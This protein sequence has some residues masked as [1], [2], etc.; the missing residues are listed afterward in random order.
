MFLVLTRNSSTESIWGVPE[1]RQRGRGHGRKADNEIIRLG[2][3]SVVDRVFVGSKG[4][5]TRERV[6]MGSDAGSIARYCRYRVLVV[7]GR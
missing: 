2:E 7:R 1:V 4:K 5:S 3:E 6:L